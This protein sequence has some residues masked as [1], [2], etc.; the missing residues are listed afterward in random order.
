MSPQQQAIWELHNQG[1]GAKRIAS[2]L[3][4]R[5]EDIKKQLKRAKL[6]LG[7]EDK[8]INNFPPRDKSALE[9]LDEILPKLETQ[10]SQIEFLLQNGFRPGDIAKRVG[11]TENAVRVY[12]WRH[13]K[14]TEEAGRVHRLYWSK[15]QLQALPAPTTNFDL[16]TARVLYQTQ[17]ENYNI[18]HNILRMLGAQGLGGW[19]AKKIALDDRSAMLHALARAGREK[20]LKVSQKES[21]WHE[22][23][24]DVLEKCRRIN[25][26]TYIPHEW[27]TFEKEVHSRVEAALAA[28][29]LEEKGT[30]NNMPV[31]ELSEQKETAVAIRPLPNNQAAIVT[32]A[33]KQKSK[34]GKKGIEGLISIDLMGI[35]VDGELVDPSGVVF[36]KHNEKWLALGTELLKPGDKVRL[37]GESIIEVLRWN[38]NLPCPR[39]VRFQDDELAWAVAAYKIKKECWILTESK[40]Y[41]FRKVK[42]KMAI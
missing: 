7:G 11:T 18:N 25:E 34:L 32:T 16:D 3:G 27:D 23:V 2:K 42:L 38:E 12:K 37:R 6:K 10:A 39:V 28:I 35:K 40:L 36:R 15:E 13:K 24:A 5:P 8:T 9:G 22:L 41:D 31:Y 4:K 17:V 26:D 1:L 21:P 19:Q 20:V 29:K 33:W 14:H 30:K